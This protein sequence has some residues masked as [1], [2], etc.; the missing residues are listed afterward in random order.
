MAAL[1]TDVAGAIVLRIKTFANVVSLV[2]GNV[3]TQRYDSWAL[4]NYAVLVEGPKGGPGDLDLGLVEQRFDIVC[5]GPDERRSKILADRLLQQLMD[6]S[7]SRGTSFL[8]AHTRVYSVRCES[9]S[10]ALVDPIRK[11]PYVTIPVLVK[12]GGVPVG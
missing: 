9:G 7:R 12:Y 4:P 1:E 3:A 6:R 2:C 10:I 8:L 5:Y 11:W